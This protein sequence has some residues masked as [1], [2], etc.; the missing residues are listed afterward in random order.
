[1]VANASNYVVT[2]VLG[3]VSRESKRE[4]ACACEG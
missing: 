2:L 3:A 4:A 1:M